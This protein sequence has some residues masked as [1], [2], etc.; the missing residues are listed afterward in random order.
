MVEYYDFAVSK[1][2]HQFNECNELQ[3]F[4]DAGKPVFRAEYPA[5]KSLSISLRDQAL[6][7]CSVRKYSN[8]DPATRPGWRFKIQL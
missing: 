7:E 6:P 2:C 1:Q 3:L 8:P 5:E 4:T